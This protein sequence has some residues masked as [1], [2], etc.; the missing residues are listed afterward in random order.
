[1]GITTPELILLLGAVAVVSV[2]GM[3]GIGMCLR[4]FEDSVRT[5][6]E[7]RAIKGLHKE[8]QRS[9]E[10]R[11]RFP[12]AGLPIIEVSGTGIKSGTE[13][14]ELRFLVLTE[15]RAQWIGYPF[16]AGGSPELF[17]RACI[18]L[19]VGRHELEN[20]PREVRIIF[21]DASRKDLRQGFA[22]RSDW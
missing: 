17:G 21:P 9:W 5:A 3:N 11:V 13:L 1:M 15:G 14:R 10:Q 16:G 6:I 22:I 7:S 4:A 2:I 18:N 8:I 20:L 19:P 12:V